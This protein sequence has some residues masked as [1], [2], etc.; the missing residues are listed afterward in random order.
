MYFSVC[1][2][3]LVDRNYILMNWHEHLDS[4]AVILSLKINLLAF[5]SYVSIFEISYFEFTRIDPHQIY[6]K[7]TS[8]SLFG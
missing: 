1:R 6:C 7:L 2:D 4:T 5:G 3:S 8:L